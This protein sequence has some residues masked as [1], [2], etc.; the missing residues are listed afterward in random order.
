MDKKPGKSLFGMFLL[1]ILRVGPE[2]KKLDKIQKVVRCVYPTNHQKHCNNVTHVKCM[3]VKQ[4][5][6]RV[7]H[8]STYILASLIAPLMISRLPYHFPLLINYA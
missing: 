7:V 3:S 2:K 4:K 8:V 5:M 6:R 1:V